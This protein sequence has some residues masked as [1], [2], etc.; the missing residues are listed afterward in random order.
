M[1]VPLLPASRR[2]AL[3]GALAG[4]VAVAACDD[5][6][7]PVPIPG[8]ATTPSSTGDAAL[9][10]EVVE[11][12]AQTAGLVALART[13]HRALRPALR[14]LVEMH[15]A[16]Q[17][18][19]DADSVDASLGTGPAG[20]PQVRKAESTLQRHLTDAAVRAESGVL[21]QLLASMAAAVA[22]HLAVLP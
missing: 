5:D 15:T 9:V 21:A 6:P 8:T 17:D 10:D 4:L 13:S 20:L 3:G 18:A 12:I 7:G 19:L 16:H 11:R 2:T 1:S 22:Q 14:P